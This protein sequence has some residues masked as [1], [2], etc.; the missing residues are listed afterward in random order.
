MLRNELITSLCDQLLKASAEADAV[1]IAAQLKAALHEHVETVRGNLLV[2]IAQ[3]T[4]EDPLHTR[5][6]SES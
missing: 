2:S 6:L 5:G 4:T 3:E 1:H